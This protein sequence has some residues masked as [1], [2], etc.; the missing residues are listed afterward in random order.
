MHVAFE[1]AAAYAALAGKDLP[2]EE[3]WRSL[4][5]PAW[6]VRPSAGQ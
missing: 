2:T 5:V 6:T 4:H 3:E 1:E